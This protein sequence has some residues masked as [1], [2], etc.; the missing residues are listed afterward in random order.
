[1]YIEESCSYWFVQFV[2][3]NIIWYGN[4]ALQKYIEYMLMSHGLCYMPITNG[5]HYIP[6][7]HSHAPFPLRAWADQHTIAYLSV[8]PTY[9]VQCYGEETAHLHHSISYTFASNEIVQHEKWFP[10]SWEHKFPQSS[11]WTFVH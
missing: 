1:M 9:G 11:L 10:G 3:L 4:I 5:L 7:P 2:D 8:L 6:M